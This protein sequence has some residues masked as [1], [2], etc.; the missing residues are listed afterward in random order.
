MEDK[1][2]YKKLIRYYSEIEDYLNPIFYSQYNKEDI[3][4]LIRE[5]DLFKISGINPGV[6]YQLLI[7]KKRRMKS[8]KNRFFFIKNYHIVYNVND[9]HY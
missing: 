9:I 5:D 8:T 1:E 6:N 7:K 3:E 4:E 2:L